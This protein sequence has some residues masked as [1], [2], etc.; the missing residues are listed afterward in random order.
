MKLYL[1]S[2]KVDSSH[3]QLAKMIGSHK[4]I[5]FIPNA[6]DFVT[7]LESK[8]DSINKDLESIAGFGLDPII[9]DLRDYFIKN[10]SLN[11]LINNTDAIFVRG[12]NVFVL[13][14]AMKKSGLDIILKEK[15]N[16]PGFVY[17]GYSAGC[18]VLSPSLKG[19][20]IV[21]SVEDMEN[22]YPGEN[23]IW[24]GLNLIDF[25]F[26]PHYKSDHPESAAIDKVVT[27]L[28]KNHIAYKTF[29]DGE[30]YIGET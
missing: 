20:E 12:G 8:K 7:D 26:V 3:Q 13:R 25:T 17:A 1:S 2:Y 15:R 9:V 14:L 11:S 16:D 6:M 23:I 21:D 4:R 18:C 19:F 10:Q 29:N 24:D 30:V 28:D 22:T 5:A 27:Y